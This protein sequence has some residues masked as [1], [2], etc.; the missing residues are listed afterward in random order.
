MQLLCCN[1]VDHNTTKKC[2]NSTN[3]TLLSTCKLFSSNIRQSISLMITHIDH[4][5]AF[6]V[7][8]D[9]FR[10]QL[11]D[12]PHS[13]SLE[14]RIIP[15]LLQLVCSDQGR[16]VGFGNWTD[17]QLVVLEGVLLSEDSAENIRNVRLD[18]SC[19]LTD[20]NDANWAAWS[21]ATHLAAVSISALAHPLY[22]WRPRPFRPHCPSGESRFYF[23]L[24]GRV[25]GVFLS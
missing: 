13:T 22:I 25:T 9:R 21:E 11:W 12:Y 20:R 6:L 5:P 2:C 17:R 1:T 10:V 14:A 15:K 18:F 19:L 23:V 4:A 3:R 8:T 7:C 16:R 24:V